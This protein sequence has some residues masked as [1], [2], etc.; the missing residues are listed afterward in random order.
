MQ[1]IF[2]LIGTSYKL[3]TVDG[4]ATSCAKPLGV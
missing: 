3:V 4:R 2:T 1:G